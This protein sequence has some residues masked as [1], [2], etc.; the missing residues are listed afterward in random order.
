MM[1]WPTHSRGGAT[2]ERSE[3]VG[4]IVIHRAAPLVR[5]LE[6]QP[7]EPLGLER[8]LGLV[9]SE[10]HAV[11]QLERL[12]TLELRLCFPHELDEELGGKLA[13]E[14]P[15]VRI[16]D[17]GHRYSRTVRQHGPAL[18]PP[19]VLHLLFQLPDPDAL[20]EAQRHRK[21]RVD[22]DV[23]ALVVEVTSFA[24][25]CSECTESRYTGGVVQLAP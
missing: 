12:R 20:D 4:G 21:L 6:G 10:G 9:G 3:P 15:A 8:D 25:Q 24:L 2:Q 7:L 19:F 16:P 5:S 18:R 17:V 14:L 1:V 13:V 23:A 22:V 11:E